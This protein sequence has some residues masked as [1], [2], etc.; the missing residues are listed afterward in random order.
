[1][2]DRSVKAGESGI[3]PGI[4][5][6][7]ARHSLARAATLQQLLV[8]KRRYTDK[9]VGSRASGHAFGTCKPQVVYG[10]YPNSKSSV[11]S[12]AQGN[13]RMAMDL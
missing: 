3:Y 11:L 12:C 7:S 13:E 2:K 5:E 4:M 1:M 10:L 8:G 6:A 9:D